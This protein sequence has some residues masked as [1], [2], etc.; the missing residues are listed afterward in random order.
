MAS[1]FAGFQKQGLGVKWADNHDATEGEQMK[2]DF[3]QE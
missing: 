3:R 2:C 1:V